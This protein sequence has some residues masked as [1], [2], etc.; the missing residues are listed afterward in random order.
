MAEQ[1]DVPVDL[2][3]AAYDDPDAAQG[4][5]DAIKQLAKDKVIAVDALI[6]VT[7][8][9]D[10]KIEV[11]DD[12][13]EVG[14]AAGIGA[15]VGLL[16]G[17]I[18]PPSILAAGV[19]GAGL[20]AGVGGLRSHALKQEIREDVA[21]DLPPGSSGIVVLFEPRW[22]TQIQ[23]AIANAS[24]VATHEIDAESASEATAAASAASETDAPAAE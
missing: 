6:L 7:R 8:D 4:D 16:V 23:T 13:H 10:G 22:L 12:F 11:K 3:I 18:F 21:N 15:G 17:L 24:S 9:L 14:V 2:Y 1:T 20:G 19:V 5:W